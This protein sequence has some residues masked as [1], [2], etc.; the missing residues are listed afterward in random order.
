MNYRLEQTNWTALV[1]AT[2][3]L[4]FAVYLAAA[5]GSSDYLALLCL[6]AFLGF[7]AYIT[8]FRKYTWQIALLLCY[9][10]LFFWPLGFRV[11][12]TELTSGLGVLLA[13]TTAWQKRPVERVGILKH[14]SFTLLRGLLLLW[15]VYVAIH[16]WY[17]IRNP[18]LPSE[19][20]LKNALKTYFEVLMP[21]ALLWY[22]SGNPTGIR[23]KGNFTRTLAILLLVG[24]IFNIALTCYGIL[25]HHNVVDPEVQ[26]SPAFLIPGINAFENPFMLRDLCP[27]AMLFG[28]ITLCL[29][30][31]V[32]AC[33]VAAEPQLRLPFSWFWLCFCSG[34]KLAP[35]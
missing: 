15:I 18:F 34:S 30:G 16:M 25:T 6:A 24:V 32:T 14:H 8:Y 5:I 21:M 17:N 28:A 1:A 13:I 33:S 20:A 7:V 31:L 3:G 11:G 2:L 26:Y 29:G 10:G 22:F 9:L 4:L 12:A 35:F 23:I 27:V 19:F